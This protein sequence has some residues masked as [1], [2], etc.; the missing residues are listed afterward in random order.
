M[1]RRLTLAACAAALLAGCASAPPPSSEPVA[2]YREQIELSGRLSVNYQ[3]DGKTESLAGRFSWRQS[4]AQTD[5]VLTS[6]LGQTV[7]QISVTPGLASLTQ[8]GQA[9]RVAADIDSLSA[10]ALGWP[11]PVS[12]L[13]DWLQGYAIDASGA[14]FVASPSRGRVTTRDGWRLHFVTWQDAPADAAPAGALR[15]AAPRATAPRPKRIDAERSADLQTEEVAIR[16]VLD[17]PE[18][19]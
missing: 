17:P 2:P 5:V 4:G 9:P 13:R 3:R 19:P 6:P 12:G 10:Q 11:L 16:I 8:G 7:A 14:R 1:I 18:T 15:A